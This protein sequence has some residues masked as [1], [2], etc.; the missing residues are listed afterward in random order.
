M[1]LYILR[2]GETEFNRRGIVQGSGVDTELNTTGLSQARAF[3]EAYED[4]DFQLVVTSAL[5]RAQQTVRHFI[6][7][8]IPWIQTADINEISW[9]EHEGL[10]STPERVALYNR[11]IS[12]WKTGNLD[13]S[14]PKGE[15]ARQLSERVGR[16]IDWIKTRPEKRILIA[17]HGRTL[18]CL[19]T[20]LKGLE[21]AE[22][23]RVSHNNTGLYVIHFQ[24]D[25]FV[26][27]VEND[28][29]HLADM[30]V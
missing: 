15:T 3:Y 21:P 8:D 10:H 26:F 22:M 29:S 4:V 24:N 14:L 5:K 13:A 30:A 16:F 6:E 12:E 1:T 7:R 18:R 19:I 17:T 25:A 2:H 11:M 9:G 23:E 27:E 20:M 28:T